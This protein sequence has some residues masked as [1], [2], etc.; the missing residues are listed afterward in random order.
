[1]KA[2][3]RSSP[4]AAAPH[5]SLIIVMMMMEGPLWVG[6]PPFCN[7]SRRLSTWPKEAEGWRG[8]QGKR[9]VGREGGGVQPQTPG[10]EEGAPAR[11]TK[12]QRVLW[13]KMGA[14]ETK[15][16]LKKTSKGRERPLTLITLYIFRPNVLLHTRKKYLFP[17]YRQLQIKKWKHV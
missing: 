10:G 2:P 3:N 17:S 9:R 5:Q 11:P 6:E 14:V 8:P 1:M 4:A 16:E 13:K 7:G 12:R 15:S